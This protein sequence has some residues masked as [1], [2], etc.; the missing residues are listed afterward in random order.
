M[1]KFTGDGS[2]FLNHVPAHDLTDEEFAVLSEEDQAR[3]KA[4]ALYKEVKEKPVRPAKE[5]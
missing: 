4:S 3:V 5:E 2:E 1:Y